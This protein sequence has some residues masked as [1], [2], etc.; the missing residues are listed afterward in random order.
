MFC[1]Y[2]FYICVGIYEYLQKTFMCKLMKGT[3][4]KLSMNECSQD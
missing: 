4:L 2:M 3:N 1:L